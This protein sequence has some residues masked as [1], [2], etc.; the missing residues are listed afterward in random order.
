MTA[1]SI[2][3][4]PSESRASLAWKI[5]LVLI[6]VVTLAF[7]I[8]LRH[9]EV[10]AL[11]QRSI[12]SYGNVPDFQ[13]TNQDGQ[14][15]GS[16]QL[17]GKVWIADFIFT[18]CRGPCPLISARM[19]GLQAPLAKTD[20]HLVSFTVDPTT[21]TPAVLRNYADGLNAEPGR[22]DFLTGTQANIYKLCRDG[23]KLAVSGSGETGAPVHSTR[24]ILVDRRGQIRG[25]YDATEPDG[26]TKL[27]ADA[28]HLLREQPR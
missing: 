8:W 11:R 21:D 13:L 26:M 27:I 10:E 7:L 24:M 12:A 15:F 9:A 16:S 28:N 4:P 25:Y 18:T 1:T 17:H 3:M 14:P 23:F 5:T 19:S 20:V 6:P 2:S 22:W